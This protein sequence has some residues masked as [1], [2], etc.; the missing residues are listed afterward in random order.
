MLPLLIADLASDLPASV[1][2]KRMVDAIARYFRCDAVGLLR[3][4]GE[5]LCIEAAYGLS[6]QTLGR[7]F[8]VSE[9]PRFSAILQQTQP[10]WFKPGTDLP[11]PYDGLL[12]DRIG[13][14]LPVHDCIGV[15]I[16][17]KGKP[18]GILTLDALETDT[19]DDQA[20]ID[21]QHFSLL[22]ETALRVSQLEEENRNLRLFS[23]QGLPA[24]APIPPTQI[25]GQSAKL[26]AVLKELDAVAP[27]ELPVMLLG[28]TG[29]GKDLF[30]RYIHQHPYWRHR[31]LV[32]INCATLPAS[33]AESE[34]FGHSAHAFPTALKDRSG[35]IEAANGGTLFLDEIAELSLTAQAKLLHT[36]QSGM[37]LRLGAD[38]PIPIKLRLITATNRDL[39]LA[40]QQGSFRA[41]L[42]H[43]LSAFPVRIPPLRERG[44][45]ILLLAGHFLEINRSRLGLRGIRLSNAAEVALLRYP[46]RGNVRELE[47]ILSRAT[48]RIL[49]DQHSRDRMLTLEVSDL[50]LDPQSVAATVFAPLANGVPLTH[51]P[52]L[53]DAADMAQ[54]ELIQQALQHTQQNWTQ[55]AQ[56]IQIDSSNLHK[57]ARKLGLKK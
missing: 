1:R 57:L 9:H 47:H 31:P 41:D 38:T 18:W 13:E 23:T 21:L 48:L 6:R 22:I 7:R 19:F 32:Y 16:H 10:T 51:W 37:L 50:Q 28:E 20:L 53:K 55:A 36:L 54:R 45:D 15:G 4:E 8:L 42:Y 26:K 33:V 29:V 40:V 12:D 14:P 24:S 56:L 34:L 2:L 35:R 11:D 52:S 46:W 17:V 49:N 44:Q 27:S 5:V 30:A 39:A 25:V 43:F 3:L